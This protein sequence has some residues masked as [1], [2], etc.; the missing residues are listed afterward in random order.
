MLKGTV[1]RV[2]FQYVG[3]AIGTGTKNLTPGYMY[4]CYLASMLVIYNWLQI[5]LWLAMHYDYRSENRF[6]M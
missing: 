6:I 1:G 3:M 4:P 2:H 5:F